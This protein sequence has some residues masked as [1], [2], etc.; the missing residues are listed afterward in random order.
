MFRGGLDKEIKSVVYDSRKVTPDSLF[1][2]IKGAVSDGHKYAKEVVE[3]G[4]TVLVVQDEVEVPEEVT[5][6]RVENTRYAMACISAAWFGHP[7]E[8]MKVN[9]YYRN[10][11]KDNHLLIW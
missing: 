7:A 6:I 8:K 4:A 5:V 9:R 1:L 10:K 11:R 2:C 3:K